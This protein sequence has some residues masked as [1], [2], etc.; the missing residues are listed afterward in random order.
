MR[1]AGHLAALC[2]VVAAGCS[3]GGGTP[4]DLP[5]GTEA[6]QA[7]PPLEGRLASGEPFSLAAERGAPVVLVFYRGAYCGLCRERLTR[8]QAH[9]AAY[10]S[11]GARVVAVSPDPPASSSELA[12][13]LGLAFP[14]VS[15]DSAVLARWAAGEGGDPLALATTLLIGGDGV[16]LFAHRGR[17][18]GDRATD[19]ALLTVLEQRRSE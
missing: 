18:A 16:V 7:A 5:V 3:P 6:G 2:L 10:R 12:E 1:L 4:A 19:A 17:N 9:L 14:L 8:L 15:A 13:R 11:L